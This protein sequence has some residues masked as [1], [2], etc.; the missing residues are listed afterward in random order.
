MNTRGSKPRLSIRARLP[1]SS[2]RALSSEICVR[3]GCVIE[4]EMMDH[5][6]D[7]SVRSSAGVIT[8]AQFTFVIQPIFA[9]NRSSCITGY[10]FSSTPRH[11]SSKLIVMAAAGSAKISMLATAVRP[12][13]VAVI[14]TSPV[15]TPVTTPA[16]LTVARAVFD[17]VQMISRPASTTPLT[18]RKVATNDWLRPIQIVARLGVTTIVSTGIR[19]V[20]VD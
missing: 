9:R 3:Y 8:P 6:A 13:L 12:S 19:T 7:C 10:A 1:T 17:D 18:S 11:E 4:C 15:A 16:A 2:V 14:V 20:I 5:P